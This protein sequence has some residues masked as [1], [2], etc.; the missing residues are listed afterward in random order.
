[1]MEHIGSGLQEGAD[2]LD[3][4]GAGRTHRF[5]RCGVWGI[6]QEG[7]LAEQR[8]GSGNVG[9]LDA[10]VRDLDLAVDEY[11]ELAR[12]FALAEED[13]AGRQLDLRNA[14]HMAIA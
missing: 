13:G 2:V 3:Q 8:A 12:F 11:V 9:D 10:A 6:E 1:M 4:V 5:H 14:A 7:H